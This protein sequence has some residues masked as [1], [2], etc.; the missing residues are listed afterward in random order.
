L[1][2]FY[3]YSLLSGKAY[4]RLVF[5]H[6]LPCSLCGIPLAI[7]PIGDIIW[8]PN[9]YIIDLVAL[10]L[11]EQLRDQAPVILALLDCDGHHLILDVYKVLQELLQCMLLKEEDVT[12]LVCLSGRLSDAL[13][14][15]EAVAVSEVGALHDQ[16]EGHVKSL[17]I[18][19]KGVWG[20]L[21]LLLGVLVDA[22]RSLP[23]L[24][25]IGGLV[26]VWV[27]VWIV[28]VHMQDDGAFQDEVD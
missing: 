3:T 1:R 14:E 4:Q 2:R 23:T 15:E 26:K 9:E 13:S 19:I 16:I 8:Q 18:I 11:L 22:D 10:P 7:T 17:L 6:V 24:N 25:I 27:N 28:K 20:L 21:G 12:L 5:P